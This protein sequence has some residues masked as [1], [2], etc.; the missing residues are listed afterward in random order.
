MDNEVIVTIHQPESYPW[1]GFFNKMYNCDKYIIL[2]SV[3]FRKNYFQNRNKILTKNGASFL[4]IPV[5]KNGKKRINEIEISNETNWVSKHWKTIIQAYKKSPFFYEIE[6]ELYDTINK[7]HE[8]LASYNIDIILFL[9][10]KLD[11]KCEVLLSSELNSNFSSSELILDLCKK[12]GATTYI[13][14]RDG[15][16]YLNENEFKSESIK[17]IYQEFELYKYEQFNSLNGEFVPYLSVIDLIANVGIEKAKQHIING[18][19]IV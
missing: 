2:D 17:I 19:E 18:W 10:K 5:K 8:L 11:I 4:T 3:D 15:G 6:D 12:T 1:C 14:G 16:N 7:K 13:S 9:K